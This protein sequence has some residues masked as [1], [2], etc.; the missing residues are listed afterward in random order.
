MKSKL[1]IYLLPILFLC[2]ISA[3]KDSND[4]LVEEG[5]IVGTWNAYEYYTDMD[6]PGEISGKDFKKIN[7]IGTITYET[8]ELPC[9]NN[10]S[11]YEQ[12]IEIFQFKLNADGTARI[13]RKGYLKLYGFR[14]DCSPRNFIDGRDQV[15]SYNWK[16][17]DDKKSLMFYNEETKLEDS[18]KLPIVTL[19]S[20]EMHIK[21]D[22]GKTYIHFKFKRG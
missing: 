17:T 13:S 9:T 19:N 1:L 5:N 8:R 21:Y 11:K 2:A 16:L 6:I 4:D 12:E 10:I 22:D 15:E 3:C 20:K 7:Q 14:F 18:R